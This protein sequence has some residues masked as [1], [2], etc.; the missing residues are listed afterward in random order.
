MDPLVTPYGALDV[1]SG[2][3][4]FSSQKYPDLY[5]RR[6]PASLIARRTWRAS[7]IYMQTHRLQIASLLLTIAIVTVPLLLYAR[8]SI[9]EGYKSLALL[10]TSHDINQ[11]RTYIQDARAH[12]ERGNFVFF[13]FSF[14]PHHKIELADTALSTG[15]LTSRALD[16]LISTIPT[17][18]GLTM[19]IA[20]SE[21]F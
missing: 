4:I 2:S 5:A 7:R 17:G 3:R 12:F 20:K 8:F 1:R 14:F 15:L 9:E 19:D 6:L 11:A 18:S 10:R 13:P 16:T 21:V